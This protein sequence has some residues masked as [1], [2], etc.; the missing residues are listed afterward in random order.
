MEYLES[1]FQI[2]HEKALYTIKKHIDNE[3]KSNFN[4]QNFVLKNIKILI[5]LKL[6]K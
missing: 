2:N 4:L 1:F 5:Q 6:K 3:Q